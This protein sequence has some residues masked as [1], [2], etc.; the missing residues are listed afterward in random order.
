MKD[1][2]QST[3]QDKHTRIPGIWRKLESLYNLEALDERVGFLLN[4]IAFAGNAELEI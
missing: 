1:D 2:G 3:P 4:F